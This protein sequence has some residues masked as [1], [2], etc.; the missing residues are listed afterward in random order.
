M[1]SRLELRVAVYTY[2]AGSVILQWRHRDQNSLLLLLLKSRMAR[3][4]GAY[5]YSQHIL[6]LGIGTLILRSRALSIVP[7]FP[8]FWFTYVLCTIGEPVGPWE[9]IDRRHIQLA[10]E[11]KLRPGRE[12]N[13]P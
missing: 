7:G 11:V 8:R 13:N 1:S 10:C 6:E 9:S 2:G 3:T 12:P 4:A 5:E